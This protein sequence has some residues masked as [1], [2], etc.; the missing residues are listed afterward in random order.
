MSSSRQ[1]PR[2]QRDKPAPARAAGVQ[3][4][5]R[6]AEMLRALHDAPEGMT[7]SQLA[8]AVGFARTTVHRITQALQ[9]E[10][11]VT[12]PDAGG[13][14]HLG[15]ELGR[16]AVGTPAAIASSIRP[17]LQHLAQ[18]VNETIALAMLY[19]AQI[20][21]VDQVVPGRRLRAASIFTELLPAHSTAPGKALLA[22]LPVRTIEATFPAHLQRS[23]P[24]TI[25]SRRELLAELE[26]VREAGVAFDR[27]ETELGISAV[28]ATVQ[29]GRGS[30]VSITIA[31]PA[32]RFYEAEDALAKAVRRT[33][34]HASTALIGDSDS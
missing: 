26:R 5:A 27:E 11:L 3:V 18:E 7:L 15:P 32:D 17:F 19:G 25:T 21:F 20:R 8:E 2:P 14:V 28:A 22:E 10:G 12:A 29:S 1:A 34:R 13:A 9:T 33:V 24:K 31:A 23:T 30:Q 16:L 6:A 4:I